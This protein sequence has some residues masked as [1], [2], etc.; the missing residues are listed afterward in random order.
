MGNKLTIEKKKEQRVF[1]KVLEHVETFIDKA[2]QCEEIYD[3]EEAKQQYIR[4]I[5]VIDDLL[6]ETDHLEEEIQEDMR[7]FVME[8]CIKC[9]DLDAYMKMYKFR[10]QR[11]KK[12][13]NGTTT[14]LQ[15]FAQMKHTY[16]QLQDKNS[17]SRR[18]QRNIA[19]I[20]KLAEIVEKDVIHNSN[21]PRT[22]SS[23]LKSEQEIKIA[24]TQ[25]QKE[26]PPLKRSDFESDVH[27]AKAIAM[28]ARPFLLSSN[29]HM[30]DQKLYNI[31][32]QC[33]F[34]AELR[35]K[36]EACG[37]NS[38]HQETCTD[39]NAQETETVE[40][41][42]SPQEDEK[43]Q[44]SN[45][46]MDTGTRPKCNTG[47]DK[48]EKDMKRMRAKIEGLLKKKQREVRWN[49]IIG[50]DAVK[51]FLIDALKTPIENPH[52]VALKWYT[53]IDGVLLFGP[54]GTGK[55][56][57][58]EALSNEAKHCNFMNPLNSDL[59]SKWLGESEKYIKILF[60][61]AKENSPCI[62]FIDEIEGLMG[63]RES[64]GNSG[65]K[66]TSELLTQMQHLGE[67]NVFIIGATNNPWSL[68]SAFFRRFNATFHVTLPAMDERKALFKMYLGKVP[69]FLTEE[70]FDRLA[71]ISE[72]YSSAH[73]SRIAEESRKIAAKRSLK[74]THFR[75]SMTEPGYYIPCKPNQLAAVA[76]EQPRKVIP[77]PMI[78][79]D[80]LEGLRNVAPQVDIQ[81]LRKLEDWNVKNGRNAN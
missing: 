23:V 4:V 51:E 24:I 44:M 14:F 50:N 21:K 45:S 52:L 53:K 19:Q 16:H 29:E 6:E 34:I 62:I 56:M 75:E 47:N 67:S 41:Q 15:D 40:E 38:V 17:E 7:Q 2:V 66:V 37:D 70:E 11:G 48:D 12:S 58:C 76:L 36:R 49:E 33:L 1:K 63:S 60:E 32:F 68:D 27:F 39:S 78:H 59:M 20:N 57:L 72:N 10:S 77:Q 22:Q 5:A 25:V 8:I 42:Q 61:V 35:K 9:D 71:M 64:S 31:V 3:F 26:G 46:K 65:G 69:H 79:E 73:I 74:S 28:K 81:Y 13:L 18:R 80:V 55:S 43:H 54:P 30:D